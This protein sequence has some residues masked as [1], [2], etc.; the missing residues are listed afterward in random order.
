MY[1]AAPP[2]FVAAT[3]LHAIPLAEG[4]TQYLIPAIPYRMFNRV[5]GFGVFTPLD[6]LLLSRA[7]AH[8]AAAHCPNFAITLSPD[9]PWP[10][11]LTLLDTW[12]LLTRAA[13][14]LPSA[15]TTLSLTPADPE[16]FG[17][18]LCEGYEMPDAVASWGASFADRPG[19]SAFL[20][21]EGETPI[22]CA[23]MYVAE[24][25]AWFGPAA[26]VPAYRGRGSQSA[27]LAHRV[28]AAHA[29][30]CTL[31][32]TEALPD[33]PQTPNPSYRNMLRAGFT[34]LYRHHNYGIQP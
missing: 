30:G 23:A 26:T 21:W 32:V 2:A 1:A 28:A 15:P 24:G 8:F 5:L 14:P 4:V 22:G 12:A 17:K 7:R 16:I 25:A 19:W 34:E 18:V 6:P 11:A 31:L 9:D 10:E 3:G 20:A 13:E 33:T 27:L 29:Q